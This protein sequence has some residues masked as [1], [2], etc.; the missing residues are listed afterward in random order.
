MGLGVAL[1]TIIW[2]AMET[3]SDPEDAVEGTVAR[4]VV[5]AV[6]LSGTLIKSAVRDSFTWQHNSQIIQALRTK[7]TNV[8]VIMASSTQL[9]RDYND[10]CVWANYI[11]NSIF[12][13]TQTSMADTSP[14]D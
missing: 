12:Y 5:P 10:G 11:I 3:E 1:D 6:T 8:N 9:H 4:E 13:S 2:V 7:C 14:K